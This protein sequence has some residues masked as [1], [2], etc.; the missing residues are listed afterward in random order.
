[1]GK[2]THPERDL[3]CEGKFNWR[4]QLSNVQKNGSQ[5]NHLGTYQGVI[6]NRVIQLE[7][8]Q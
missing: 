3:F 7:E 4:A 2:R 1:V 6:R 8:D 5:F